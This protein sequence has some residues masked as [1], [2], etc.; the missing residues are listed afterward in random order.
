MKES[1]VSNYFGEQS[2]QARYS[3]IVQTLR[4]TIK[5]K[6]MTQ[7]THTHRRE[8]ESE[9]EQHMYSQFYKQKRL[10]KQ[11]HFI[12]DE[13]V[14]CCFV[15]ENN[16]HCSKSRSLNSNIRIASASKIRFSNCPTNNKKSRNYFINN[17]NLTWLICIEMR[18]ET[19]L[20]IQQHWWVCVI[21]LKSEVC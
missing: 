13:N 7:R 15:L 14:V 12:L 21:C 5:T 19:V 16:E 17:S 2:T 3:T 20:E 18:M 10:Y 11:T 6:W 1:N 4:T 9:R 8:Q